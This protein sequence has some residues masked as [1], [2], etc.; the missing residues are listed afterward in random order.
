MPY[1]L[2]CLNTERPKF[3]RKA[4]KFLFLQMGFKRNPSKV[5]LSKMKG[6]MA[7]NSDPMADELD[8]NV[9]MT[10]S[11]MNMSSVSSLSSV[12]G[13]SMNQT[14]TNTADMSCISNMTTMSTMSGA[15]HKSKRKL[16][17]KFSA[18]VSNLF[19]SNNHHQPKIPQPPPG[20]RVIIIHHPTM[21]SPQRTPVTRS[22]SRQ[23]ILMEQDESESENT[24]R[25]LPKIPLDDAPANGVVKVDRNIMC[26][27]TAQCRAPLRVL[28]TPEVSQENHS[29][30]RMPH[31]PPRQIV[32]TP[33]RQFLTPKRRASPYLRP[34]SDS[35]HKK[36]STTT[37]LGALSGTP[38][39][40]Q[41]TQHAPP[42]PPP[43]RHSSTRWIETLAPDKLNWIRTV[44]PPREMKRQEAIHELLAGEKDLMEDLVM[45][46]A[47][48][49]KSLISLGIISDAEA[50]CIFGALH[51]LHPVHQDLI[52]RLTSCQSRETHIFTAV[53]EAILSWVPSLLHP[54]LR[55]CEQQVL[56]KEFLETKVKY[57]ARFNEFLR[58]CLESRFSRRLDLWSIM[59]SPRQ[60]V[61][62]YALLLRAIKNYTAVEAKRE[63]ERLDGA[64]VQLDDIVSQI[65][66]RMGEASCRLLIDKIDF[67]PKD[68]NVSC[69]NKASQV[70]ISGQ[71]KN[72]RSQRVF[73]I[74]FDTGFV[75]TKQ[76]TNHGPIPAS[77]VDPLGRRPIKCYQ[78]NRKPIDASYLAFDLNVQKKLLL[79]SSFNS[80][81]SFIHRSDSNS[82]ANAGS[83]VSALTNGNGSSSSSS[84]AFRVYSTARD[85]SY[86]FYSSSELERKQWL[87]KLQ[88][89]VNQRQASSEK[90]TSTASSPDSMH[91][92]PP[93]L[94]GRHD[95]LA[96]ISESQK[97]TDV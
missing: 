42:Q 63:C 8:G 49:Q 48:Y 56:S 93:R 59:D 34:V 21:P 78:L 83:S 19:S 66:N 38:R 13:Q 71:L 94:P 39:A 36:A 69:I 96:S 91:C 70:L 14:L 12:F 61:C 88:Q 7:V 27:N 75:V 47:T 68:P 11:I 40:N 46:E 60:R 10:S 67:D 44:F 6:Q 58:R 32:S 37:L 20:Q 81:N 22:A 2:A 41:P 43:P 54:Y 82:I 17:S 31:K 65:D 5:S 30:F 35:S 76:V 89:L 16:F 15:P 95:S 97:H 25:P 9:T 4:Y 29:A 64:I 33:S 57:D 87:Q 18:S 92:D 28:Q 73:C 85:V 1:A 72:S 26:E 52:Q 23:S 53:G 3:S 79:S 62:R 86:T 77:S 50:Y 51:A 84:F 74:L 55:Y 45:I 24:A 90:A 80:H